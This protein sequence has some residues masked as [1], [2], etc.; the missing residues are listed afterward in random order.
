MKE[1]NKVGAIHFIAFLIA[2][3]GYCCL[4]D[5]APLG[6][7]LIAVSLVFVFFFTKK[8]N[9]LPG[10]DPLTLTSGI[11]VMVVSFGVICFAREVGVGNDIHS[12]M[13]FPV[14]FAFYLTRKLAELIYS[15]TFK[16]CCIGKKIVVPRILFVSWTALLLLAAAIYVITQREGLWA[17]VFFAVTFFLLIGLLWLLIAAMYCNSTLYRELRIGYLTDLVLYATWLESRDFIDY[18][19]TAIQALLVSVIVI[20]AICCV[21]ERNTNVND[22]G[23]HNFDD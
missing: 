7:G 20:D 2:L 3:I 8:H 9:A 6:I 12:V 17:Y 10:K 21:L 13:I 22:Y 23:I 11:V 15:G 5:V 18:F 14:M 16:D 1:K 19:P 4:D